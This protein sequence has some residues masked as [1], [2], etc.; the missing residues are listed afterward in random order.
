M[1]SKSFQNASKLNGIVSVLQF[2][3]VGDGVTDDTAAI[4]AAVNTGNV[5]YFPS[6]IYKFSSQVTIANGGIRG[7]SFYRTFLKPMMSSGNALLL[8]GTNPCFFSDFSMLGD[9]MTSGNGIYVNGGGGTVDVAHHVFQN[10]EFFEFPTAINFNAASQWA[11]NNCQFIDCKSNGV[12]VA[13]VVNSDSGDSYIAG[14]QF[15]STQDTCNHVLYKSSGGLRVNNCKFNDGA[16]GIN[17]NLTT[18]SDTGPMIVTGS[19]FENQYYSGINLANNGSSYTFER[20]SIVGNNFLVTTPQSGQAG[21]SSTDSSAFLKNVSICGNS[22]QI[23][24]NTGTGIV[25]DYVKG[26]VIDGNSITGT[27]VGNT[28]TGIAIGSNATGKVGVNTYGKDAIA[29]NTNISIGGASNSYIRDF[30]QTGVV[31]ITTNS[32]S[33][34]FW[35]GVA[36]VVLPTPTRLQITPGD[37]TAYSG[38][39]GVLG[40]NIYGVNNSGNSTVSFDVQVISTTN[41]AVV[42]V[43]WQ[44]RGIA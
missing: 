16:V 38:L 37:I 44:V 24:N 8:N 26:Y 5:V 1:S 36:N 10:I 12:V 22:F 25:L 23:S 7:E 40:V 4:Q 6:G 14:S 29:V 19:S 15:I 21:I 3:A 18:T 30:I 39:G 11:I 34:S 43:Q 31:N 20:V 41:G 32:A 33:G 13:N 35:T 9:Q 2:G 27:G 42:P 17:L 28:T